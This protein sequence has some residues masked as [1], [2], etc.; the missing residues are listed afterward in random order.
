MGWMFIFDNRV[1]ITRKLKSLCVNPNISK[2]MVSAMKKHFDRIAQSVLKKFECPGASIHY[3]TTFINLLSGVNKIY[4]GCW[5]SMAKVE[6][7]RQFASPLFE[8]CNGPF[9]FVVRHIYS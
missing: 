3:L 1:L 2:E 9:K 5:S 7:M 4:P 6:A 8:T